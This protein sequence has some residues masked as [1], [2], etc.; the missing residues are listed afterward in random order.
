MSH[1]PDKTF[2]S[3]QLTG[4]ND[5]K[6]GLTPD[7]FVYGGAKIKKG[8][9]AQELK[10]K[11]DIT[12]V[13]MNITGN[14][15][16]GGCLASPQIEFTRL[17]TFANVSG[18]VIIEPSPYLEPTSVQVTQLPCSGVITN[19]D[20][21]DGNVTYAPSGNIMPPILDIYQY[22]GLDYCGVLHTVTQFVCS[23]NVMAP[24]LLNLTCYPF[25]NNVDFI[26]NFSDIAI[27]IN[28]M[29]GTYPIDW[30]TMEI[31]AFDSYTLNMDPPGP[32]NTGWYCNGS[33]FNPATIAWGTSDATGPYWIQ[34]VGTLTGAPLPFPSVQYTFSSINVASIEYG[35]NV[36]T[37]QGFNDG[38]IHFTG[39][40]PSGVNV[41]N[42]VF[43]AQI[44]VKDTQGNSS[45]IGTLYFVASYI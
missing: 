31:L 1:F 20:H 6:P 8:L 43:R 15:A 39:V 44:Q 34:P 23:Q 27:T 19:I 14:L 2:K 25:D 5:C 40:S 12:T 3:L 32:D 36:I 16:V 26:S 37:V 35:P 45:N 30:T 17:A 41:G 9:C 4:G 18:N 21:L 11:G 13:N 10:I 38:T 28:A 33:A 7:L 22:T 42:T 24:P 29:P